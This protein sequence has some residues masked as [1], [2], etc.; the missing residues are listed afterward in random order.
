MS[1]QLDADFAPILEVKVRMVALSLS[2]HG[3]L[4]E[5]LDRARP[6]LRNELRPDHLSAGRQLPTREGGHA[7]DDLLGCEQRGVL[8]ATATDRAGA[9]LDR[10][11]RVA[12]N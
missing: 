1:A 8:A 6:I 7:L 11:L 10:S 4:V 2:D 12:R 9:K 5:E 3:E